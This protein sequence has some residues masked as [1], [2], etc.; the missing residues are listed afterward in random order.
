MLVDNEGV[1]LVGALE[2]TTLDEFRNVM[3]TNVF[4]AVPHDACGAAGHAQSAGGAHREH[5]VG[6]GVS[7]DGGLLGRFC[8]SKHALRGLSEYVQS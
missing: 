1:A 4:G 8:A 7:A 3:D 6:G 5:R 2:E